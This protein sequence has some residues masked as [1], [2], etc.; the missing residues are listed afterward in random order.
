M[1]F[2][3]SAKVSK[4]AHQSSARE[5]GLDMCE[6]RTIQILGRDGPS[7]INQVADRI[8]MDRGGTSRAISRLEKRGFIDRAEVPSD[9]RRSTVYLTKQGL[10]LHQPI[11]DFANQREALLKSCLTADEAQQLDT[12]LR[13]LDQQIENMLGKDEDLG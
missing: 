8:S 11:A 6:W 5:L 12:V 7:N 13:K 4:H 3:L 1:L 2:S 9:R 10:D